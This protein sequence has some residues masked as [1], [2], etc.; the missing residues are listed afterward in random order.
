MLKLSERKKLCYQRKSLLLFFALI[1]LSLIFSL[2]SCKKADNSSSPVTS[3]STSETKEE[4]TITFMNY[5]YTLL[6]KVTVK[7]GETASYSGSTPTKTGT[8]FNYTFHG[9]DHDLTDVKESFETFALY[10]V[11]YNYSDTGCYLHFR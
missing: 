1:G 9:W 8:E 10:D 7:E 11:S 3:S 2:G 4:Y 5:D 6:E